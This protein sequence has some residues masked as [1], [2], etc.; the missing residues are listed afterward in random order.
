[1][2]LDQ[3]AAIA[4]AWS[5]VHGFTMLLLDNRLSDILHR[6]P[7]GADAETLLEAML[8]SMVIRPPGL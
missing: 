2:S 8:K 6:L 4:R 7:E 1:L 5:L 3:A